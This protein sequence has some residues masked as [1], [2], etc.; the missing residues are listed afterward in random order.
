[1]HLLSFS[2]TF[3]PNS[4][5]CHIS[6]ISCPNHPPQSP[7]FIFFHSLSFE[8]IELSKKSLLMAEPSKKR[9]SSSSQSQRYS[10]TQETPIPP[11]IPSSS[12]FSS[13]EQRI[14]Y[15]NLYSSR[16]IIDPKFIDMDFFSNGS[17][18]CI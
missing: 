17:F 1:M 7:N 16:S 3:V 9:K 8:P 10:E 4:P 14:R 15:T 13:E 11:S 12:L 5:F 2:K 6:L 18:E